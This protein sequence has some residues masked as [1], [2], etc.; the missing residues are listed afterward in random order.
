M[1]LRQQPVLSVCLATAMPTT[2]NLDNH[3]N[4]QGLATLRA[5]RSNISYANDLPTDL[6]R[7]LGLDDWLLWLEVNHPMSLILIV[8]CKELKV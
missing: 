6:T 5:V 7:P 1:P 2:Y 8:K 4:L 3:E